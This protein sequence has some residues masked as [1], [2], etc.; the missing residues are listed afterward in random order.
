[1]PLGAVGIRL[2]IPVRHNRPGTRR[3]DDL[4]AHAGQGMAQR[5][6]GHEIIGADIKA[7]PAQRGF[8]GLQAVTGRVDILDA[9]QDIDL[10]V[11]RLDF[12]LRRDQQGGVVYVI[13]VFLGHPADQPDMVFHRHGR[14]QAADRPGNGGCQ[15]SCFRIGPAQ[16]HR[17]RQDTDFRA[18]LYGFF[19]SFGSPGQIAGSIVENHPDLQHADPDCSVHKHTSVFLYLQIYSKTGRNLRKQSCPPQCVCIVPV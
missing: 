10:P 14:Q 17:F 6:A 19:H 3:Q 13:A 4:R 1:M 15:F 2:R 5:Q 7:D 8:D 9:G 18:F 11:L 12:S 16:I